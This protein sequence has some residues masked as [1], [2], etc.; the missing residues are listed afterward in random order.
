NPLGSMDTTVVSLKYAWAYS[1]FERLTAQMM[2]S[3]GTSPSAFRFTEPEAPS[4]L[5][6]SPAANSDKAWAHWPGPSAVPGGDATAWT[7]A[8]TEV[9]E[10]S[11]AASAARATRY[12]AS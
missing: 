8:R 5:P 2:Y 6:S 1:P 12:A 10:M 11:A 9:P 7:L 3:P 4:Y